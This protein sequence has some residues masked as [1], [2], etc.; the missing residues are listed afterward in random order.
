MPVP[1]RR[2][3]PAEPVGRWAVHGGSLRLLLMGFIAGI[4]YERGKAPSGSELSRISGVPD[5]R[6]SEVRTK[7]R[8]PAVG[9]VLALLS[10]MG[11]SP[12]EVLVPRD[13]AGDAAAAE[14]PAA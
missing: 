12:A 13:T 1:H 14:E 5:E 9:D 11:I 2:P 8:A 4:G 10:L 7:S 6:I 3:E